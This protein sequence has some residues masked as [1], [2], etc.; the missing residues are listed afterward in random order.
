M[1]EL[2]RFPVAKRIKE[3]QVEGISG[4]KVQSLSAVWEPQVILCGWS[5]WSKA[6][7]DRIEG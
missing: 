3:I 4:A 7:H 6:R 2:G 5:L 1:F